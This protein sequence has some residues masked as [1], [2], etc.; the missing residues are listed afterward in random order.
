MV[1]G[2]TQ[3]KLG[4]Q[5]CRHIGFLFD[6]RPDTILLRHWIRKYPDLPP[7]RYRYRICWGFIFSHSGGR[8]PKC[9]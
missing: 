5:V 9:L 2:F 3:E 4:L 1:S 8:I 6:K 7:T